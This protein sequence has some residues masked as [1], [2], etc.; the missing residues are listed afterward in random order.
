MLS[1]EESLALLHSQ[2]KNKNLIKHMLAAEAVM[3]RLADYLGRTGNYGAGPG[4]F[5]IWITTGRRKTRKITGSWG[6]RCWRRGA[7]PRP[8]SRR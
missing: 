3:G 7:A 5:T 6:R 1:R 8:W 2:V 4:C